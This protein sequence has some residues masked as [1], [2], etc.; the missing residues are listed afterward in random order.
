MYI[1]WEP[2]KDG[3]TVKDTK[4]GVIEY[5]TKPVLRKLFR[6]GIEIKGITCD[7]KNVIHFH[8]QHS[9]SELK[10]LASAT[11]AKLALAG[12][13]E[14]NEEYGKVLFTLNGTEGVFK[15]PYMGN[16]VYG[17]RVKGSG[18]DAQQSLIVEF[19]DLIKRINFKSSHIT[20]VSVKLSKATTLV[21][22][23]AG[24]TVENFTIDFNHAEVTPS[25]IIDNSCKVIIRNYNVSSLYSADECSFFGTRI[26]TPLTVPESITNFILDYFLFIPPVL[27]IPKHVKVFTTQMSYCKLT[28]FGGKGYT[29]ASDYLK[30]AEFIYKELYNSAAALD[31]FYFLISNNLYDKEKLYEVR[32]SPYILILEDPRVTRIDTELRGMVIVIPKGTRSYIGENASPKYNIILEV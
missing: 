17:V 13:I 23:V 24:K 8:A 19:D 1:L 9:M 7:E 15:V 14:L 25:G 29:K 4:D 20:N 18:I 12:K 30:R 3:Y 6:K 5:F 22:F 2:Y 10:K 21:K 27:R 28:R 16:Y 32:K 26:T 11:K 31:D